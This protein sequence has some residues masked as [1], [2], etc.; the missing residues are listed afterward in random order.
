MT[1][2]KP[3]NLYFIQN[4]FVFLEQ[5]L[6]KMP[7]E[8]D[9]FA[10]NLDYN[11]DKTVRENLKRDVKKLFP[12]LQFLSSDEVK[13]H[14]FQTI[15]TSSYLTKPAK[16]FIGSL[17]AAKIALVEDGTFDYDQDQADYPFYQGKELYLFHP[18]LASPAAKTRAKT[19]KT[20]N[21]DQKLFKKFQNL[22]KT[23]LAELKT[24]PKDTPVLFTTPLEED[25]HKTSEETDKILAKIAEKFAPKTLI[26]KRHPRDHFTYR[27]DKFKIVEAPQNLPGQFID[28]LFTGPKIYLEK[29]TVGFMSDNPEIML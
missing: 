20:L 18:E 9:F 8:G 29:S 10:L 19:L 26:L 24:L 15:F 25:F 12:A 4:L 1:T 5:C 16:A 17:K 2:I 3:K 21:P 13:K 27:T 6:A 11:R 28:R 14:A 22:Y 23:E 7:E